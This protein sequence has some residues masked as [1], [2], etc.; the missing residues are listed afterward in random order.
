MTADGQWLQ[1]ARRAATSAGALAGARGCLT[2][3]VHVAG[4]VQGAVH[5]MVPVEQATPAAAQRFGERLVESAETEGYELRV[6]WTAVTSGAHAD[7]EH[8]GLILGLQFLEL[9]KELQRIHINQT[10]LAAQRLSETSVLA[11]GDEMRRIYELARSQADGL[12]RVAAQFSETSNDANVATTIERLSAQMRDFGQEILERTQRQARDIEQARQWTND[13]VKLGQAIAAIASN[14][15]ILTFNAR[16]ESAR[17]GEAGRGFAVIAGSIQELATQV[18]QT[19]QAVSQLAEN[20]AAALP[21]LGTDAVETSKSAKRSVSQLEQ[22][23]LDVQTRLAGARSESWEALSDSSQRAEELQSKANSV[24]HHLQF[25]DRASQMLAEAVGQATAVIE[26]AGLREKLV[27]A[28][29]LEQVGQLGRSLGDGAMP[30]VKEE[31]SIE[32]F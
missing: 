25:Q 3:V 17:I 19:N 15:R 18:R 2:A 14:A 31:G 32:L 28:Q 10:I 27:D 6:L 5:A 12:K 4:V 24:I 11:I 23:L 13:I 7:V 26:I 20:L 29:V 30:N 1:I 9:P 22:Q 16:L 8:D 21:R